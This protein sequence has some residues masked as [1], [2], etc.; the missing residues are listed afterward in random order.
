MNAASFTPSPMTSEKTMSVSQVKAARKESHRKEAKQEHDCADVRPEEE[1]QGYPAPCAV[2]IERD[3]EER[4]YE[5]QFKEYVK[6]YQ[7]SRQDRA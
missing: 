4:R 2:A 3:K 1:H 5:H 6:F 7:V